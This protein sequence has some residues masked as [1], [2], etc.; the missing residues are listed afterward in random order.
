MR[1]VN[2]L[3]REIA[4]ERPSVKEA[5]PFVAAAAVPLVAGALVFIGYTTAQANATEQVG[6]VSA[7]RLEV[8]RAKPKVATKT[9]DTSALV[10]SRAARRIALAD[11]LGKEVAWDRTL[12]DVTRVLPNPVWLSDMTV[13]SPT[14]ADSLAVPVAVAAP[15]TGP[16]SG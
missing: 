7:L 5:L 2:L 16:A 9:V 11:V 4:P 14:P 6:Q 13:V 15:P 3:P 12:G 8:A 10:S 1:A